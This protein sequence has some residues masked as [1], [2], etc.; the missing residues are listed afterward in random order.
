MYSL[1]LLLLTSTLAILSSALEAP[2]PNH[3]LVQLPS[4]TTRNR[5]PI[6]N[7]INVI[8]ATLPAPPFPYP[9][10]PNFL[11]IINSYSIITS[12]PP[13]TLG[14]TLRYIRDLK[15]VINREGQP[16]DY[17]PAYKSFISGPFETS[18][19]RVE[20]AAQRQSTIRRDQAI[21]V[22]DT[23][24]EIEETF[25]PVQMGNVDVRLDGNIVSRMRVDIFG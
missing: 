19:A 8:P 16:S 6:N 20:F 3:L 5:T 25:G 1:K 18:G 15:T 21:R 9:V 13:L 17:F 2:H 11:M 10:G 23:L 4:N 12:F 7:A 14:S 24:L 22:L